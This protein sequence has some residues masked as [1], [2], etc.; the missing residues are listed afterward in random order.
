MVPSKVKFCSP[1][2]LVPLPPVMIRLSALLDIVADPVAPCAPVEPVAP[3]A[4]VDP[5]AP[6]API[7]PVETSTHW[8]LLPS[9]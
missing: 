3:C 8:L 2:K 1:T 6:C 4:P 5:P 7:G 9:L